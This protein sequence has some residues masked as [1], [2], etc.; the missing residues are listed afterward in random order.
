MCATVQ[1]GKKGSFPP[2]PFLLF[3]SAMSPLS[4]ARA[5]RS[6]LASAA[7]AKLTLGSVLTGK[8]FTNQNLLETCTTI[9][10]CFMAKRWYRNANVLNFEVPTLG[11]TLP[12]YSSQLQEQGTKQKTPERTLL[13]LHPAPG[14][15]SAAAPTSPGEAGDNVNPRW[16][17]REELL[18]LLLLL[19][20]SRCEK[21]PKAHL[22][23]ASKSRK[24]HSCAFSSVIE[25]QTHKSNTSHSVFWGVGQADR[26]VCQGDFLCSTKCISSPKKPLRFLLYLQ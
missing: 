8:E 19:R 6:N 2:P 17:L 14:G 21:T 12:W 18:P 1:A 11:E 20:G 13:P 4:R 15:C 22:P 3:P 9:E 16:S 24:K 7:L 25:F 26:S 5:T 10:L 23:L